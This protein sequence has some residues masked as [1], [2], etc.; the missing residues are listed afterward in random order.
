MEWFVNRVDGRIVTACTG[1]VA[2][3]AEEGPIAEDNPELQAFL[4]PVPVYPSSTPTVTASSKLTIADGIM[5]GFAADS[6]IAGGF[7]LDIGKFMLF[8][9]SS[10]TTPYIVSAF[11][12][13]LYRI[14]VEA[15]DYEDDYFTVT[16][17]D[18][19]G[20]PS[21]PSNMSV[22]IITT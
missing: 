1:F 10:I 9:K 6:Q 17:T 12:G 15:D 13:G 19:S 11:D 20:N 18:L 16:C 14:Y 4:N 22:L 2:G 7:Q 21:D 8:F 3:M 5:E